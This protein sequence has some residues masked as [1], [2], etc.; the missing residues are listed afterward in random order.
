MNSKEISLTKL[1]VVKDDKIGVHIKLLSY[2]HIDYIEDVL[3]EQFDFDY[4][5]RGNEPYLIGV[6][7]ESKIRNFYD[8]ID[9]INIHHASENELYKTV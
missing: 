5:F 9:Q 2:N 3:A 8:I 1:T 4:D 7:E 6:Y